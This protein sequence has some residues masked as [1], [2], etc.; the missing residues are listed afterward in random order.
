MKK[1]KET[2]N[3]AFSDAVTKIKLC[4]QKAAPGGAAYFLSFC[5]FNFS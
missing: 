3:E 2:K 1:I 5:V 4:E